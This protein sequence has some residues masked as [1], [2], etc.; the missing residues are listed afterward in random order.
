MFSL[1]LFAS[2]PRITPAR[3][4]RRDASDS[5]QGICVHKSVQNGGQYRRSRRSKGTRQKEWPYPHARAPQQAS[6]HR[7]CAGG[8]RRALPRLQPRQA[9]HA[10]S[11]LSPQARATSPPSS[12]DLTGRSPPVAQSRRGASCA[13]MAS[14]GARASTPRACASASQ[15]ECT[16]FLSR[17]S[18]GTRVT[19]GATRCGPHQSET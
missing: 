18:L 9:R 17:R 10:T 8:H 12:Q 2:R 6:D 11:P 14:F 19:H 7:W 3:S 13:S 5:P 4:A 15:E 16:T 1:F